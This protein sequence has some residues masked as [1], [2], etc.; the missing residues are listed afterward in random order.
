MS[1]ESMKD[2]TCPEELSAEC[3]VKV[4]QDPKD[5][6]TSNSKLPVSHERLDRGHP[7]TVADSPPQF[8]G[9]VNEAIHDNELS[10][11]K[12][13]YALGQSAG[14]TSTAYH[15]FIVGKVRDCNVNL[16]EVKDIQ[17]KCYC[18]PESSDSV[19]R[20][21]TAVVTEQ[22][23]AIVGLTAA[24]DYVLVRRRDAKL[25]SDAKI[26]PYETVATQHRPLIC[27]M[28][29]TP[30]KRDTTDA[31]HA[32]RLLVEKH[33]EKQRPLHI[34]FLDLEKAFDRVPHEVIWYAL[35]K[36]MVPEELISW[37]RILYT[38]PR[39]RVQAAAGTSSEFPISVGVHQGSPLSPLLF[40]AVMDAV[41]RDLQSPVPWSLLYADDVMLASED[42][43]KL[44]LLVQSW[45]DRLAQFGLRL[46]VSKTEYLTTQ[47]NN[48]G[49][50]KID[51]TELSRT[52]AFKYLGSTIACDSSL[53]CE[54]NNR[55]SSAWLKW[56][57]PV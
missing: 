8:K 5:Q 9:V 25:V 47:V 46:S 15:S 3:R 30:P 49:T 33:R 20:A 37:V 52:N 10:L 13:G 23:N 7:M 44:E 43:G 31:I 42:R 39:S 14:F 35:R 21:L 34:A 2:M 32:A 51:G 12:L 38:D 55:V 24:I 53:C 26:V 48:P 19:A 57:A 56:R 28:K 22:S 29:I 27:T 11:C 4:I 40:I 6:S 45:C 54:V 41:T 18:L 50:V 16:E 17:S 36:Q 1:T